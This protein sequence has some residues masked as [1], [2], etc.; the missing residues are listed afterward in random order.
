[1]QGIRAISVTHHRKW[2][3]ICYV[4]IP[5][6]WFPDIGEGEVE[7]HNKREADEVDGHLLA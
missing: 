5:T 1:M 4:T 7:Q 6:H 2:I 3:L